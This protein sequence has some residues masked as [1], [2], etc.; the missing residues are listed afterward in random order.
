MHG[1]SELLRRAIVSGSRTY[2]CIYTRHLQ[3]LASRKHV[4]FRDAEKVLG[5]AVG[6]DTGGG[7]GEEVAGKKARSQKGP[8]LDSTE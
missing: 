5:L 2:A 6:S 8:K 3:A 7:V 1:D 4:R